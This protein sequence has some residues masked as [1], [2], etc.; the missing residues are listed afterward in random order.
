MELAT[1]IR[2]IEKG[3]VKTP[4][5]QKWVDL[6]A[7]KGLFTIAL[8]SL[9]GTGSVVYAV[10]KDHGALDAIKIKSIPASIT[11]LQKN[12]VVENLDWE[13]WDGVLMANA[14]HFVSDPLSLLQ[15]I[16]LNLQPNGR[17][18]VVEYNTD[19]PN[20]WVPH[21]VSFL[22]LK[23]SIQAAGFAYAAKL[24]EEPSLFNRANI[25]SAVVYLNP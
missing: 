8:A 16:K 4:T 15:K 20:P 23:K 1:A 25:Y 5:P 10:D 6:G 24:D 18:M 13:K 7:G 17:L 22:S 2:L 12:F 9:L 14:L 19:K 3:V 21:P 11:K